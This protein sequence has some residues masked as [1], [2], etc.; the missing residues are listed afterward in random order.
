MP[1]C[2]NRAN[3]LNV[4]NNAVMAEPIA[5]AEKVP[6]TIMPIKAEI[7]VNP[8]CTACALILCFAESSSKRFLRLI[9]SSIG[10]APKSMPMPGIMSNSMRFTNI[11]PKIR[12]VND[13]A[14]YGDKLRI[15]PQFSG[16]M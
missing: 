16:M 9:R 7:I 10:I 1:E 14:M 12:W 5:A 4:L 6:N 15:Y 13:S 11:F 2:L 3:G 8:A